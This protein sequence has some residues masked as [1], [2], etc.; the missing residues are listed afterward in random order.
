MLRHR[1]NNSLENISSTTLSLLQLFFD[2]DNAIVEPDTSFQGIP[3]GSN[4]E[5]I[6]EKPFIKIHSASAKDN[7]LPLV[8]APR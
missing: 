3:P 4:A 6:L 5:V 8:S 7:G 2:L 1:L